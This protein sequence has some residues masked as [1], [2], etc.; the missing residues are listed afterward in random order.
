LTIEHKKPQAEK[1][2]DQKKSFVTCFLIFEN[3]S[4]SKMIPSI[5]PFVKNQ[6]RNSV[7]YDKQHENFQR[8]HLKKVENIF[9][10]LKDD[11]THSSRACFFDLV[12]SQRPQPTSLRIR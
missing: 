7:Q 6:S 10:N 8:R 3:F 1:C 12:T 2:C 11:S 4:L 5:K 9:F